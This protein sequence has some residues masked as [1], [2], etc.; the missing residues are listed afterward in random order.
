MSTA[1]AKAAMDGLDGKDHCIYEGP[2]TVESS[3]A[4]QGCRDLLLLHI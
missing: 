2:P 1:P 4:Q 3:L